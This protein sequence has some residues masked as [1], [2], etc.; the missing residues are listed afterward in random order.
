V[1]L[2]RSPL[3]LMSTTEELLERKSNG[4]GIESREHCRRDP[5]RWPCGTLYP[6]KLAPTSPTSCGRSVCI[7]RS[8]TQVRSFIFGVFASLM[9]ILYVWS[10]ELL[11]LPLSTDTTSYSRLALYPPPIHELITDP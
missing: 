10:R 1:G 2:E 7:V 9:G 11:P 5:S 6:Q 8:R 3:S 4:S